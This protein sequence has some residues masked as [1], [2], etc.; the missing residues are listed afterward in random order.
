MTSAVE[1]LVLVELGSELVAEADFQE[2]RVGVRCTYDAQ[3]WNWIYHVYLI[4]EHGLR[5]ISSFSS[6]LRTTSRMSAV[7]LGMSYAVDHILGIKH[8]SQA[9]VLESKDDIAKRDADS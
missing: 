7:H 9:S 4:E 2:Y 8:P 5:C 1:N 6:Q 3:R